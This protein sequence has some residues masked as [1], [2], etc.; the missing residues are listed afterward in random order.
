MK[1]R[2]IDGLSVYPGSRF[3]AQVRR[4]D[5]STGWWN[6]QVVDKK[7]G[8]DDGGTE[9]SQLKAEERAEQTLREWR[10]AGR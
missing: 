9:Q 1:W 3:E 7:L 4:R 10:R 8:V 5:D 6:W 2:R